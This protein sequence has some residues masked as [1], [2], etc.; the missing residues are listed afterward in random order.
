MKHQERAKIDPN[1]ITLFGYDAGAVTALAYGYASEAQSEGES[2]NAGYS[3]DVQGIVSLAGSLKN[4]FMCKTI[5]PEPADCR[6]E[7]DADFTNDITGENQPSLLV[8]HGT[9]D[10]TVPYANGLAVYERAQEV[11]LLSG[12]ITLDNTGHNPW[13]N[14]VRRRRN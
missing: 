10:R 7:S 6:I 13:R 9:E 11:G 3:S 4:Q 5:D 8:I 2:G 12:M 14:L 1:R